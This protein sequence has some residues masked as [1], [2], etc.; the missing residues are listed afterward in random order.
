M[1]IIYVV[2]LF[3]GYLWFIR[4]NESIVEKRFR[5]NY[6]MWRWLEMFP[7]KKNGMWAFWSILLNDFNTLKQ[8]SS[9]NSTTQ[10]R[11]KTHGGRIGLV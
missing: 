11:L 4:L 3:F 9:T 6:G 7:H 8:D 10:R 2:I 5:V 1:F